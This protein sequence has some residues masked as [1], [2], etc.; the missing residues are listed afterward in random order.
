MEV[1]SESSTNVNSAADNEIDSETVLLEETIE[2]PGRKELNDIEALKIAFR[3][4]EKYVIRNL[5]LHLGIEGFKLDAILENN[6]YD[7]TEAAHKVLQ[8]CR[9]TQINNAEAYQNILEVLKHPDVNL[10]QIVRDVFPDSET[11]KK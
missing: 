1:L 11:G 7:I 10:L 4:S 9:K 5:G 2:L 6:K 8:E 3:L